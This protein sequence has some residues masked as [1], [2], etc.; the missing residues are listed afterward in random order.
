MEN[1]PTLVV[2]PV[3]TAY[4]VVSRYTEKEQAGCHFS[5]T[6]S[7]RVWQASV[8]KDREAFLRLP[9]SSFLHLDGVNPYG[10]RRTEYQTTSFRGPL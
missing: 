3:P 7:T 5:T 9:A 2:C 8:T 6:H 10:A 1:A 4:S